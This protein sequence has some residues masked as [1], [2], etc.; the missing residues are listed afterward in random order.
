M[1]EGPP[2]SEATSSKNSGSR[3]LSGSSTNYTPWYTTIT[4]TSNPYAAHYAPHS[5][6][7]PQ[8]QSQPTIGTYPIQPST[9]NSSFPPSTLKPIRKPPSPP[10]PPPPPSPPLRDP[11][12][13]KHWDVVIRAFFLKTGLIQALKGFEADMLVLNPEWEQLKIPLA[14][15]EMVKGLTV[16]TS[17]PVCF[18]N[19]TNKFRLSWSVK[20]S[21]LL[22][23]DRRR[24]GCRLTFLHNQ[25]LPPYNQN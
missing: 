9:S 22:L 17:F 25:P 10:P 3:P 20:R 13:Y 2:S 14:L 8:Y 16:R 18:L 6:Y 15:E 1:T 21:K 19:L 11:E 23:K 5:Y 24:M 7:Y 4:Q 12:T